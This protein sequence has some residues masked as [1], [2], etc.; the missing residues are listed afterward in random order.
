MEALENMWAKKKE[1]EALKE[2][3]KKERY[4]ERLA[5]EKKRIELKNKILS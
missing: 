5:L 4:D 1:A 2:V 3:A